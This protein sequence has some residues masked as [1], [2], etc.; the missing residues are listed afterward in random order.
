VVIVRRRIVTGLNEAGRSVVIS[1]DRPAKVI[2]EIGWAELW[3]FDGIPAD[4][5]SMVEVDSFRLTPI[6][7]RI[8]VRTFTVYPIGSPSNHSYERMDYTET[9]ELPAPNSPWMHRT[10]TVDIIVVI[11]GK[12]DLLLDEGE[13]LQLQPGDSVVQRG[14]M[15]AWRNTGSEPCEAV[16]FMVRAG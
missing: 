4:T 13:A 15:H 2:D 1:D 16:A 5:S 8:A 3:Q 7:G 12:M 6:P 10:P 14:T 11:S 9:E